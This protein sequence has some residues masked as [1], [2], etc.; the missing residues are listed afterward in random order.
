MSIEILYFVI[1]TILIASIT[2]IRVI[3]AKDDD[4]LDRIFNGVIYW[5]LAIFCFMALKWLITKHIDY[6]WFKQFGLENVY[7]TVFWTQFQ[8]RLIGGAIAAVFFG[9][10]FYF[11]FRLSMP[12]P[13]L[14]HQNDWRTEEAVWATSLGRKIVVGIFFS[15]I[16]ITG[17]LFSGL[18]EKW[19]F[20]QNKVSFGGSP[21]P[22][23]HKDLSF[24]VADL[25]LYRGILWILIFMWATNLVMVTTIYLVTY[26]RSTSLY[27]EVSDKELRNRYFDRSSTHTWTIIFTLMMLITT[28]LWTQRYNIIVNG[29]S[30]NVNGPGY[31]DISIRLPSY[32]ILFWVCIA[33]MIL[34]I[35]LP[36]IFLII[37]RL[38]TSDDDDESE[39]LFTP[40]PRIN[41][42]SV[43]LTALMTTLTL[44]FVMTTVI[45]LLAHL[46]HVKSNQL[47][48][49]QET[50]ENQMQMTRW[51]YQL[52]KITTQDTQYRSE[53]SPQEYAQQNELLS[54]A[55]TLD[56]GPLEILLDS[57]YEE[58]TF[59]DFTTVGVDRYNNRGAMVSFRE[60]NYTQIPAESQT[61]SNEHLAYTSGTC[62]SVADF[63]QITDKSSAQLFVSSIPC[64][65]DTI[66]EQYRVS[67]PDIYFGELTD[68]WIILNTDVDELTTSR[69]TNQVHQ[70]LGIELGGFLDRFA[71]AI[72]LDDTNILTSGFIHSDSNVLLHRNIND[73]IARIIPF[74]NIQFNS[75]ATPTI[76]SGDRYYFIQDGY[77]IT[78]DLPLSHR[79]DL[80][81][82]KI[83]YIR[84]SIRAVIDTYEGQVQFYVLDESDPILATWQGMFPELF[85]SATQMPDFITQHQLYPEDMF[86]AQ[87]KILGRYH[88][89]D[90]DSFYASRNLW[91]IPKEQYHSNSVEIEPR[92][93]MMKFPDNDQLEFTLVLPFSA[94]GNRN[95]VS[96]L[97]ARMDGEHFGQLQLYTF[98]NNV[99]GPES[100]ENQIDSNSEVRTSTKFLQGN[101]TQGLNLLRANMIVLLLFDENGAVSPLFIEPIYLQLENAQ[102]GSFP[103]LAH[104]VIVNE[105]KIYHGDTLQAALRNL[106]TGQAAVSEGQE[107]SAE[108]LPSDATAEQVLNSAQQTY[109]QAEACLQDADLECFG[110]QWEAL[111]DLL[112][113]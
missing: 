14:D 19:L 56:W 53:L 103:T 32:S 40:L 76:N 109:S 88:E 51:A 80:N 36:I 2:T 37:R 98:P 58:Q 111:G 17:Y 18:W 10:N 113:R 72:Y 89:S 81:G 73:R 48:L 62:A 77:S 93:V 1:V 38:K 55:R 83:N 112:N 110:Q 91:T 44:M 60:I 99:D 106:Y 59:Y 87:A 11:A 92:Y 33:T 63:N 75:Y 7:S 24:Y 61:W 71:M 13:K 90:Y 16:L 66:P 27:R 3:Y 6:L 96:W 79:Y 35:V 47:R 5:F 34:M 12:I 107:D 68:N 100:V 97:A 23:H 74:S 26:A 21:D 50:I 70:P 54:A 31:T 52:D 82:H 108:S 15:L 8:L 69:T 39:Q 43:S 42:V 84:G 30:S 65:D 104:V 22:I 85:T 101:E 105:E 25:P 102:S 49:D 86:L 67:Y 29:H 20:H 57:Q 4:K 45:P 64:D 46:F 9:T 41:K 95:M 28:Y 78:N 94:R